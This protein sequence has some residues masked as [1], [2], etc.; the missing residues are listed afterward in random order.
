MTE[1][2]LEVLEYVIMFFITYLVAC[3]APHGFELLH[4]PD[5]DRD[6]RRRKSSRKPKGIGRRS[7]RGVYIQSRLIWRELEQSKRRLNRLQNDVDQLLLFIE[8]YMI[9]GLLISADSH[10]RVD[11]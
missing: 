10:V 2:F 1:I 8:R 6:H 3:R 5:W 11:L 7:C 4:Y 9:K